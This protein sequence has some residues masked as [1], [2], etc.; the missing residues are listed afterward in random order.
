MIQPAY[1]FDASDKPVEPPAGYQLLALG[2]I[3]KRGDI[4]FDV[5]SGWIK[6]DRIPKRPSQCHYPNLD[7]HYQARSH[8]RW[9]A[10]ARPL[11]K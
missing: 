11:T 2:D 10:W 7:Y 9:T 5:Y 4:P 8:G 3:I 1:G 6:P